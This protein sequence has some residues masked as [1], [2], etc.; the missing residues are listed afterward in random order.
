MSQVNT[1][2]MGRLVAAGSVDKLDEAVN[3]LA[4]LEALH[5]IDYDGSEE[6]FSLGSQNPSSEEGGKVLLRAR[7]AASIVSTEGPDKPVSQAPIRKILSGDLPSR[8]DELLEASSRVDDLENEIS[9]LQEEMDTLS[10]V[11]PVSYTHLTLPTKA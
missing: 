10:M 5:I 1:Q 9:S 7:S 4:R 3:I 8:I 6:G 2:Q 11:V